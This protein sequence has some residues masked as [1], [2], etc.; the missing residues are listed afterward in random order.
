MGTSQ[1]KMELDRLV[2][3][4]TGWSERTVREITAAFLDIAS[5][6]LS[7]RR[8]IFLE[9]IGRLRVVRMQ[10]DREVPLFGRGPKGG[11]KGVKVE[12]NYRVYFTKSRILKRRLEATHGKAR[13]R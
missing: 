2:S 5:E 10:V 4:K 12:Q 7:K 1:V 9:S 8:E 6:Q 13:R 3:L 11:P